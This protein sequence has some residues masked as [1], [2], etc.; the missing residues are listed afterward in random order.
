MQVN[1]IQSSTNP[2]LA[3]KG[4]VSKNA[5]VV[6]RRL[7]SNCKGT[8]SPEE[9]ISNLKNKLEGSHKDNVFDIVIDANC[10]CLAVIRN[11]KLNVAPVPI[12]SVWPALLGNHPEIVIEHTGHVDVSPNDIAGIYKPEVFLGKLE[13][14][15]QNE[16]INNIDYKIYK[17]STGVLKEQ[18]KKFPRVLSYEK[19][20]E[21]VQ[22]LE[23]FGQKEFKLEPRFTEIDVYDL[24]SCQKFKGSPGAYEP[25]SKRAYWKHQLKVKLG[26]EKSTLLERLLKNKI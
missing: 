9:T 15:S 25:I 10:N 16:Y 19:L 14:F 18:L 5:E 8:L 20:Q 17:C 12:A 11:K 13:D 22:R 3:F 1:R 4:E 26:L 23:K 2:N 24:S 7:Y 6:I 21:I